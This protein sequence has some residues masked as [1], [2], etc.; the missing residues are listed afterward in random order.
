MSK[1]THKRKQCKAI[2]LKGQRCKNLVPPGR[3]RKYCTR[4]SGDSKKKLE[5][6][7]ITF[8]EATD[9]FNK[10]I[11]KRSQERDLL[12]T[13]RVQ[14]NSPN[15]YWAKHINGSDVLGVD[16]KDEF[17]MQDVFAT[18]ITPY[19][20][21]IN[22]RKKMSKKL[23]TELFYDFHMAYIRDAQRLI[24]QIR[25][26]TFLR[27]LKSHNKTTKASKTHPH[28]WRSVTAQMKKLE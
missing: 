4:H 24:K 10:K 2:T 15:K 9:L 19:I 7:P 5:S 16:S 22:S 28:I 8:E 20:K 27:G 17:G 26:K 21:Q 11:S 18:S 25:N 6:H 12:S 23:R 1:T 13:S 3:G 14:Y